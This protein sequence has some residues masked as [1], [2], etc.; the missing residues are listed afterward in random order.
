MLSVNSVKYA[1]AFRLVC[2]YINT[3]LVTSEIDNTN[4]LQLVNYHLHVSMNACTLVFSLLRL[5]MYYMHHE[6]Q[7]GDA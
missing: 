6:S 1:Y 3:L 2:Q 4:C 5:V 7:I